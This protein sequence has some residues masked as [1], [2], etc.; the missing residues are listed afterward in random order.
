MLQS[1]IVTVAD[2]HTVAKVIFWE[3]N[4][5]KLQEQSSSTLNDFVIREYACSRLGQ[6]GS[7][8]KPLPESSSKWM[9]VQ[10]SSEARVIAVVQLEFYQA[11]LRCVEPQLPPF[12]RCSR[13][14]CEMMQQYEGVYQA[15]L[16]PG[17]V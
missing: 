15:D 13:P 7:E 9:V 4:V 14:E 8:M 11:C 17:D 10:R 1:R 2:C 3:E 16:G 5:G 12:R 6:D